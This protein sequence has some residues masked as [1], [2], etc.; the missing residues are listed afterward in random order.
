[1]RSSPMK[2]IVKRLRNMLTNNERIIVNAIKKSKRIVVELEDGTR[3][4]IT[5][6]GPHD[7]GNT[8]QYMFHKGHNNIRM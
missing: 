3:I 6:E 4:Y 5:G 1:M 2:I 8:I 7:I